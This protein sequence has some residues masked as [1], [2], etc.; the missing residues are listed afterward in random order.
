MIEFF[1][2]INFN[3]MIHWTI[4]IVVMVIIGNFCIEEKSFLARWWISLTG[5]GLGWGIMFVIAYFI[6][7]LGLVGGGI[8]MKLIWWV[9][10]SL[11]GIAGG[12]SIG[13][14]LNMLFHPEFYVWNIPAIIFTISAGVIASFKAEEVIANYQGKLKGDV[15]NV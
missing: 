9:W 5:V 6:G 2:K 3:T 4:A 7:N 14:C 11:T 12:V 15:L 1:K 8:A 10:G 13:L